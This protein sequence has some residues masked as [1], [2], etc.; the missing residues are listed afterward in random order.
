M[1]SMR[2]LIVNPGT[3]SAWE[4]P[5]Q[6]GI[7]TLGREAGNDFVI[8]HPSV[9]GHHCEFMV[10]DSGVTVKDLN[11]SNGT[12][13]DGQPV[14]ESALLPGQTLQV[15][16]VQLRLE[17]MATLAHT[18]AHTPAH[19]PVEVRM[20]SS[21]H[22]KYHPRS[23][24]RYHCP[25]CGQSVCELCVNTRHVAGA[26][27]MFCRKCA[28]E[29]TPLTPAKSAA[30]TGDVSFFG[31]LLGAFQFPLKGDGLILIAAGTF[32]LLLL[33]AMKFVT[34]FGLM[35][36][37]FATGFLTVL[38]V[39]YL[40]AYLRRILNGTALGD[41]EMPGWPE[42]SDYSSDIVVPFRQLV[43]TILFCFIPAIGLAIYA[44]F[45]NPEGDTSWMGWGSLASIVLGA[46]YFPMAFMAVAMF[47]SVAAVNPLLIVPSIM[48]VLKEYVLVVLLLGIAMTVNGLSKNYL[49][50]LIPIPL[51]PTI[52]AGLLQLY[53]L[54][55]VMRILGLL[56]REKQ[57][58]LAWF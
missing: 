52:I 10:M 57:Y 18:Q 5:L 17:Q 31:Q 45:G 42:I 58:E 37:W 1:P 25:K 9:S 2:R 26:S 19:A 34:K 53:L 55:V 21:A 48:K 47:D 23:A 44:K 7:A 20:T 4:I 49:P 6:T 15:G 12:Q 29:C 46:I 24:A 30:E 32:F 35:Y 50:N 33:D 56:Y 51:V 11:S 41:D 13:I 40:T 3:D 28:V 14:T 22:C 27:K 54:I 36:G 16:E 8:Q 39:G 43:L 38:G